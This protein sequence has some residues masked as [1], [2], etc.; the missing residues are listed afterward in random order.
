M[1][2]LKSTLNSEIIVYNNSKLDRGRKFFPPSSFL[3]LQIRIVH[4]HSYRAIFESQNSE[5]DSRN[6]DR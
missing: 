2:K 6:N 4:K 3:F 5:H 1:E